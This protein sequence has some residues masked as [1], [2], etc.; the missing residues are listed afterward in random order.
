MYC[1]NNV[2]ELLDILEGFDPTQDSLTTILNALKNDLDTTN[3]N[4]VT[5]YYYDKAQYDIEEN[6]G[7]VNVIQI[8]LEQKYFAGNTIYFLDENGHYETAILSEPYHGDFGKGIISL[9]KVDFNTFFKLR[10]KQ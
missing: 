7:F 2:I 10:K 8:D 9:R 4:E 6:I 5:N 3:T 1:D